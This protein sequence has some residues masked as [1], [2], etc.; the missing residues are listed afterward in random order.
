[1]AKDQRVAWLDHAKGFCIVLVVMLYATDIVQRSA[2]QE[3]WLQ[4]VVSFAMPFRMP[5]FFLLSGLLVSRV[6]G[7]D[8]RTYLDRKVAHFAYFYVLWLSIL[9]AFEAPWIAAR[10]G[11]PAVANEY[12]RAYVH[13]Y[14]MLW[15]IYLLPVFFVVTRLVRPAPAALVWLAAAALQVA[16][17]DTGLKV[18]D[19]FAMYFVYFYTG[20]L[21]APHVFRLADAVR[22]HRGKA[23]AG[24]AVWAAL[25]GALVFTG[26]SHLR[27]L[28]LALALVGATA[29]IVV[30]ALVAGMP[31]FRPFGYCG[32]NSIVIYLAFLIPVTVTRKI[33]GMTGWIEDVG[34]MSLVATLGGVVGALA[35]YWLVRGTPMRFLFER[36]ERFHLPG[37]IVST[38]KRSPISSSSAST[39]LSSPLPTMANRNAGLNPMRVNEASDG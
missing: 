7:R 10:E 32:R 14:S 36:P 2:G 25:N 34:W 5:D 26:Y 27:V 19:K 21:A 22:A 15:F 28:S 35:M 4:A 16:Q 39:R 38:E 37:A 23:L 33:L 17:F 29:V 1:M 24:L 31:A 18:F 13:P 20:S 6:I 11:W 8:W 3:G 9:L 12:L 30:A